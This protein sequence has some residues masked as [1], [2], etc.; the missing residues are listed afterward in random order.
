MKKSKYD[1][2]KRP[3]R[4]KDTEFS[5]FRSVM[6]RL[7]NEIAKREAEKKKNQEAKKEVP[8]EVEYI[9]DGN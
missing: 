5:K 6:A 7:D 9:D 4:A 2:I 8:E 1:N 3:K